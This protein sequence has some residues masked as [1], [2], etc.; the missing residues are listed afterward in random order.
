MIV[1][2]TSLKA[3]TLVRRRLYST[4]RLSHLETQALDDWIASPRQL[5]L[6][7]AFSV[8]RLSD[9]Y[10]TLPTRDG[11]R[12]PYKAP[13]VSAPLGYGAH[14]AFFHPRH[15]ER[16]LRADGTDADFCPPAPLTR[17]MWAGGPHG[18]AV[19]TATVRSVEKKGFDAGSPMVFVKQ[20]IEI[21]GAGRSVPSVVEERSHVYIS[22]AVAV[23]KVPR[24]VKGIPPAADFTF[25]FTPS[26]TTL[27]RFSALTFNGHHIH[28]DKD[29][30][31]L[32]E[33]YPERLVHGPLTALMLLE[34]TMLQKP[35]AHFAHF[36]YRARNPM[37]VGRA[38]TI[39][40]VWNDERNVTLWVVNDEGVVGMTGEIQLA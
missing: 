11:T 31:Q 3:L 32:K 36:E 22:E 16:D 35:G 7:D 4:R 37:V 10:I 14:L 6:N 19:S 25:T 27:F 12:S 15:P 29:Y 8:D 30:A 20:N 26:L 39:A 2:P 40:G 24:D 28:L 5:V 23:N 33:G 34:T 18:R 38:M 21:T 9:L 13:Q 17:R 1:S